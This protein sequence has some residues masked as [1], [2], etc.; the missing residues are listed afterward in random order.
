MARERMGTTALGKG[1]AL[2]HLRAKNVAGVVGAIGL[3]P[4][5]TDFDSLDGAP[6]HVVFLVLAQFDERE[7]HLEVM[8]RLSSLIHDKTTQFFLGSRPSPASVHEF[9]VDRDAR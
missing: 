7:Q 1:C 3:I 5:G 4:G 2:P 6:T 9:L 8:G